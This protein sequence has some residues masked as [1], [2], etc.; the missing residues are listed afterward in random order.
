MAVNQ[1]ADAAPGVP[2]VSLDAK[3]TVK[4]GPFS[5]KEQNR[6]P[7]A[8]ADHDF[9]PAATVTPVGL[10]LPALDALFLDGVTSRV[11]SDCLVD[12]LTVW[13]EGVRERWA[14]STTRVLNLDNGPECQRHRTQLMARLVPFAQHYQL[15]VRLASYPPDHR[16][17]HPVARCWGLREQHWHGARLDALDAVLGV[18]A[19]LT[20]QGRHPVV[21][22]VTTV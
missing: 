10:F 12:C 8:A 18:A 6:G 3:A 14:H 4:V 7:T 17:D 20:G 15:T 22:R 9:H 16:Q 11:T 2:R 5:R 1:A 19:T 21:T 13:W